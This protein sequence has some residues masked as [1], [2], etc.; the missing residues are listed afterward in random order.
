MA[1]GELTSCT[2]L[3]ECSLQQEYHLA[4]SGLKERLKY[5]DIE[6]QMLKRSREQ[7]RA[8]CLV[9]QEEI[10]ALTLKINCIVRTMN[11]GGT[12]RSRNKSGGR[13]A[14]NK[15]RTHPQEEQDITLEI[16]ND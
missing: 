5:Q 16:S 15:E 8:Q 13:K 3:C 6:I 9:Q 1:V 4:I 10:R 12:E 11:C 7:L 2:S 14:G